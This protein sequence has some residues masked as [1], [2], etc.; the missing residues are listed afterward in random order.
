[1][2]RLRGT[3]VPGRVAETRA[4]STL[5][6]PAGETV[7]GTPS[8]PE[9]EERFL[10]GEPRSPKGVRRTARGRWLRSL[11]FLG[12]VSLAAAGVWNALRSD[13]APELAV[14]RI[15]VE[16]NE[17]LSDGEILE[18]IEVSDS[19]NILTLDLDEVKRKLLRS[20]WVRDVELKRVLPGTLT[21]QIVERA[22][23]AIAVLDDLYLLAEDGTILDQ[24]PPRYDA[25]KLVLVRGLRGAT[26]RVSPERAAVAGRLARSL[27]EDEHFSLLVSEVDLSEGTESMALRLRE[28]ALTLLV[29]EGTAIER[30]ENVVPL[31]TGIMERYPSVSVV[32]LRFRNRVYLRLNE[33]TPGELQTSTA[34]VPGGAPF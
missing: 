2:E 10:R 28:P 3:G 25:S 1:V 12:L 14:D 34:F 18:L 27:L 6:E 11:L 5:R 20:T 17:R 21:L 32:D 7:I 16:G 19:T 33:P 30:L 9:R 29:S 24:L 15:L 26:D 31:L 22:P 23:V 13:R 8:S 4:P